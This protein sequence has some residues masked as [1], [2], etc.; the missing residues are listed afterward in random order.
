MRHSINTPGEAARRFLFGMFNRQPTDFAVYNRGFALHRG[1]YGETLK[2]NLWRW[3]ATSVNGE[4]SIRRKRRDVF[5][6]ISGKRDWWS[7]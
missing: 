5:A 7:L 3:V 4:W 2:V 6:K 1:G